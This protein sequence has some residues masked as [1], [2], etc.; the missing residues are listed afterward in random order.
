MDWSA[1]DEALK[2]AR[3]AG[4]SQTFW[5][6]DDDAAADTPAL[7]RL[8]DLSR[9]IGASLSLAVIPSRIEPSLVGRLQAEEQIRAFVH[10]F[11]HT[12]HAPPGEKKAEFGPHRPTSLMVAEAA[13]AL[14]AARA[15]LGSKLLPV[16]V[17]PWNRIAPGLL[18]ALPEAG[19]RGVSAFGDR[20]ARE[21][22]PS[23]VQVNTHI[24][25]IDWRGSR[26]LIAPTRIIAALADAVDRRMASR[27][28]P[29]EP[30]GFL[31]HHLVQDEAV[32]S[33]CEAL[34]EYFAR[35]NIRLVFADIIFSE[36][37]RIIVEP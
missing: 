25:P 7:Q 18:P 33:F 28:D 19:Y 37:N 8:L 35:S 26:S 6:R 34:F 21:A 16:F 5:W 17:P 3:G 29:D 22:A 32:W 24:D 31:T 36:G 1:L 10:G 15:A 12:N 2:R 14:R 4:R 30:I 27:A 23:L 9:R 11:A 20:A 13:A